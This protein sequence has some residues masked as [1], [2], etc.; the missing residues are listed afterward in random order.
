MYKATAHDGRELAIK[1]QRPGALRQVSLDWTCLALGLSALR[2]AWSLRPSG[3]SE[4]LGEVADEIARGVFAE[5]DYARED[6]NKREFQRSLDFLGF[7]GTPT[8][9]PDFL[10]A[11]VLASEWVVGGRHL[12]AISDQTERAALVQRACDACTASLVLTGFVH[13]DPHEGNLMLAED[14]RV[15]FLDFGLMATVEPA[16]I[17][18]FATGIQACLSGDYEALTKVFQDVGFVG[19]PIQNRDGVGLPYRDATLAELAAAV[20]GAMESCEGGTARF[21]AL[22]TV[23]NGLSKQWR[24]F[25]PPYV[26]LLIRTFLTLEGIAAKVD[27]DFNIYE[28]SMPWAVKRSLSPQSAEGVAGRARSSRART[29]CSGRGCSSS[30]TARA[31][32]RAPPRR[33]GGPRRGGRAEAR[34]ASDARRRERRRGGGASGGASAGGR[35][36]RRAMDALRALLGSPE[37]AALARA[38]R[39]RLDRPRAQARVARGSRAPPRGR[40]RA[41]RGARRAPRRE[42]AEPRV[43][44]SAARARSGSRG[45]R[46]SGETAS[47]GCSCADTCSC[48]CGPGGTA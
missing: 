12:D 40:D 9:A 20:R 36:R 25:T 8:S 23:L 33:R 34:R 1:V 46:R 28:I 18:A 19:T 42:R 26:V 14:G 11:R 32:V 4:D 39:R 48:S 37:G 15:I 10:G 21:G 31:R 47:R 2:R 27:P 38:R 6:A 45:V 13:A 16:I 22:A 44:P 17:E 29:A 43:P 41:R 7:V 35:E 30:S 5:L 24:M 3:F